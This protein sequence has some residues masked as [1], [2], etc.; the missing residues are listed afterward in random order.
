MPNRQTARAA[1]DV[2]QRVDADHLA[3]EILP[4]V[5]PRPLTIPRRQALLEPQASPAGS[6]AQPPLL[7]ADTAAGTIDAIVQLVHGPHSGQ[8]AGQREGR[9]PH[10]DPVWVLLSA[11]DR[12]LGEIFAEVLRCD[13]HWVIEAFDGAALMLNLI[14][15][16][17]DPVSP[18]VAAVVVCDGRLPLGDGLA[19]LRNLREHGDVCPPFLLIADSADQ[20]SQDEARRLGAVEVFIK[21]FVLEDLRRLMW[22]RQ[23]VVVDGRFKMSGPS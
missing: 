14:A 10:L 21:P 9:A 22:R 12:R 23:R 8:S 7:A 19:I 20:D 11:D 18:G 5:Y 3:G 13:G 6:R 17:F 4:P 16:G 1:T 2:D 15:L